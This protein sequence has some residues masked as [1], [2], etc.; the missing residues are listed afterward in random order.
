MPYITSVEQIGYD[1]RTLARERSITL[2]MLQKNLDLET[3]AEITGLT[4]GQLA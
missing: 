2:N 1:R 3:I 4:I